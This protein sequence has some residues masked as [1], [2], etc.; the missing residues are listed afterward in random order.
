MP[1]KDP[2]FLFYSLNWLQ[3]TAAMKPEEKGVY[4]DLLSHQHQNGYIPNDP[5]RLCRMV[6]LSE[7]E[8]LPIWSTVRFKFVDRSDNRL[9]NLKLEEVMTERSTKRSTT[10]HTKAILSRYAVLAR[11]L[12]KTQPDI[13]EKIKSTFKVS[14]F[15]HFSIDEAIENLNKWFTDQITVWLTVRLP[16]RV[17]NENKDK[18]GLEVDVG[19]VEGEE[20]GREGSEPPWVP[21]EGPPWPEHASELPNAMVKI[22]VG[23]FPGYPEQE[24]KD[25]AACLK[26]AY[27]IADQNGWPWQSALNGRMP[28]VLAKW[29][30]IVQFAQGD[31]WFSTRSISDLENEYQ[32]LMQKKHNG[33][34]K[35]FTAAGAPV[36]QTVMARGSRKF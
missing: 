23:A 32:R 18:K 21:P 6:G 24:A 20:G 35:K 30:E 16:T 31:P 1:G 13:L 36:V 8:F 28:D 22:F 25:F 27:Y 9:V 14:D 15:E 26:I 29:K 11:S 34:A 19:G 10:D 2:A 7:K 17:E 4:I 3:G 5:S 12:K 33:T